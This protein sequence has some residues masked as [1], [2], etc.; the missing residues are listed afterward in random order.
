[1]TFNTAPVSDARF[2]LPPATAFLT[3]TNWSESANRD[4]FWLVAAD[5]GLFD[6]SWAARKLRTGASPFTI[7]KVPAGAWSVV[8]ID[9]SGAFAL[10]ARGGAG[11]LPRIAGISLSPGKGQQISMKNG[12][13][14]AQP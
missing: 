3:L 8:Q 10:L 2:T 4:R 13:T 1:G 11:S 6:V 9:S 14:S 7:P 5:G 12:D